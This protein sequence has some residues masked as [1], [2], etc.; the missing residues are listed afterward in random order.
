MQVLPIKTRRF[1]PPQDSIF[2]D[3][4]E[5]LVTLPER[6]IVVITSKLVSIDQ[7]RCIPVDAIS[8]DELIRKESDYFLDRDKVPGSFV[9]HTITAKTLI[10][11]AGIDESNANGYYILWPN[12]IEETLRLYHRQLEERFG[13]KDFGVLISDSRSMPLRR[14]VVGIALGSYGF[15]P[16]NDY[17]GAIDL[18]GRTLT[19]SQLN[20]TDSLAAAA[21]ATMGEGSEQTPIAL[22]SDIPFVSF[23]R[24][25]VSL[26]TIYSSFYVDRDEDIYKPFL[27]VDWQKGGKGGTT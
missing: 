12:K 16:I 18:F 9:M 4:L 8:K 19:A 11:S 10:P 7:G 26:N 24:K 14:G 13:T 17:R 5:A 23:N 21:V 6:S 3:S 20:V 15:S 25:E 27:E 2:P 22:I 1:L